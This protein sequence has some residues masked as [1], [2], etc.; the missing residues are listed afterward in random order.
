MLHAPRNQLPFQK[1]GT[2]D[3]DILSD[4]LNSYADINIATG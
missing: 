3:I 2:S 4:I 1:L